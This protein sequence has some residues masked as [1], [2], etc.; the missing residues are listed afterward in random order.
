MKKIFYTLALVVIG[1]TASYAQKPQRDK[2]TAEQKAERAATVLE[3]KL[4]LTA[5]QKQQ[6]KQIELDRIKKNDEWRNED[7]KAIKAKMEERKVFAQANKAKLD[8]VLTA[9]QQ[10]TLAASR[11][12]MRGKIK[13][14]RSEKGGDRKGPRK[15]KGTPPPPPTTNN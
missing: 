10:K 11:D 1:F 4:T 8:A 13:D 3:K 12:E 7:G 5:E 9:D 6:V 14:R 15:G 2:L